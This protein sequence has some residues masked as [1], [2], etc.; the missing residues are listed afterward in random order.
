MPEGA[1]IVSVPYALGDVSYQPLQGTALDSPERHAEL[2]SLERPRIVSDFSSDDSGPAGV[3]PQL[4]HT[5]QAGLSFQ[6]GSLRVNGRKD[7]RIIYV[8]SKDR[9][10]YQALDLDSQASNS[11]DFGGHVANTAMETDA[12]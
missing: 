3:G 8:L 1:S 12:V 4:R 11:E 10:H 5:F 9:R 6:A 2:M 7:R